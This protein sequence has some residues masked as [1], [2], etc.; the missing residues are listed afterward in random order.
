MKD[1]LAAANAI[2]QH[3]FTKKVLYFPLNIIPIFR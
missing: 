3:N 2:R 1:N